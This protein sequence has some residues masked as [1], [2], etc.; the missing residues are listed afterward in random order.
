MLSALIG[1][2]KTHV[3][4]L[5]VCLSRFCLFGI[6]LTK[7][8]LY[9]RSFS[10][11]G[12]LK[13]LIFSNFQCNVPLTRGHSAIAES[14]VYNHYIANKLISLHS[15]MLTVNGANSNRPFK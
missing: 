15:I 4:C 10:P 5:S 3:P 13:N 11:N 2:V 8:N 1:M 9:D 14:L 6:I 12:S 7:E